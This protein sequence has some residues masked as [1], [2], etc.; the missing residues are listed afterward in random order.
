MKRQ[1]YLVLFLCIS[2]FQTSLTFADTFVEVGEVVPFQTFFP[3][4]SLNYAIAPF[5]I[6]NT[7]PN[8]LFTNVILPPEYEIGDVIKFGSIVSASEEFCPETG[9][10]VTYYELDCVAMAECQEDLL[11]SKFDAVDCTEDYNP[12]CGCDGQTYSNVCQAQSNGITSYVAGECEN[13]TCGV[14]SIWELEWFPFVLNENCHKTAY[15]FNLNGQEVI[16]LE[17]LNSC[18]AFDIPSILFDCSGEV[19]CYSG[20]FTPADQQCSIQGIDLEPFLI[21]SNIFWANQIVTCDIEEPLFELDWLPNY[22]EDEC[23]DKIYA[24]TLEGVEHI[25]VHSVCIAFDVPSILFNCNGEV[26]CNVDGEVPFGT[27]CEFQ[28]IEVDP[29]LIPEHLLWCADTPPICDDT[30]PLFYPWIQELIENSN[31]CEVQSITQYN[32]DGA[33]YFLV[34]PSSGSALCPTDIPSGL[35]DCAGNLVCSFGFFPDPLPCEI[36]FAGAPSVIIWEYEEPNP[37]LPCGVEDIWEIDWLMNLITNS[38]GCDVYQIIQYV[39]GGEYYFETIPQQDAINNECPADEPNILYNCNGDIVCIT[40]G[41]APFLICTIDIWDATAQQVVWTYEPPDP[42]LP[43]GVEEIWD[44]DWLMDLTTSSDG[45]EVNQIIQYVI[46]GAYYFEA[47]PLNGGINNQCPVDVP[48]TLYDCQGNI[49][50]QMGGEADDF[51]FCEVDIWDATSQQIVW[52]YEPPVLC[53]TPIFSYEITDSIGTFDIPQSYGA[54]ILCFQDNIPTDNIC[55]WEWDFGNGNTSSESDP[56]G[57]S[58]PYLQNTQPVTEPYNVCLTV[59]ECGSDATTTCCLEIDLTSSGCVCPDVYDPVCGVDGNTY[60]NECEASCAGVEVAFDGPCQVDP[61]DCICPAVVDPVCGVDGNTYNNACEAACAGVAVDYGSVCSVPIVF[62]QAKAFLQGAC[63][64]TPGMLMRDDLR[65]KGLIPLTEPYSNL[66]GFTHLNGGGETIPA[67]MLNTTGQNAIVD[68]MFMELRDA[69]NN[70]ICT[71]SVLLQRDGDIV[72]T[73][74]NLVEIGVVEGDYYVCLRHRNHLG[75]MTANTSTFEEGGLV[76]VNFA[77]TDT[78]GT[79]AQA[80]LENG[81]NGLWAGNVNNTGQVAFQ[82]FDNDINGL[83]FEVLSA[84]NNT[85]NLINYIY[86]G[87]HLGDIDMNGETIY[88][89]SNSDATH[90]FFMILQH[91]ENTSLISNFVIYEQ[92]P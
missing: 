30:D 52:N 72:D 56:C 23:Y 48:S 22:V 26:I 51:L 54:A 27:I 19:I 11:A 66:P 77:T 55:A 47:I 15:S 7:A 13:L 50:C 4:C 8:N 59:Y 87:Y 20:G 1:F 63:L 64:G 43:C 25:F 89:G 76:M 53:E 74:G 18:Q 86:E 31:G 35:F 33:L 38:N 78:Y 45:C 81:M 75:A 16:F 79:N 49:V 90:L 44:I 91:P 6:D 65:A 29:Y 46:D 40:G 88:Q 39:I 3:D 67:S 85:N 58:F 37:G 21:P 14:Q 71:R 17:A 41:E 57:I 69:A 34:T 73:D 5:G 42:S 60:G 24:F 9:Q 2:L 82:G 70:L 28:G 68:W 10:T 92:A 32:V 61:E 62:V 80:P 36:E 84:P 83:F 12:L